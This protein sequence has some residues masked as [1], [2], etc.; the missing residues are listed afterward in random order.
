[1]TDLCYLPGHVLADRIRHGELSAVEV[2]NAQLE[3][4]DKH[5]PEL[6]AVVSLDAGAAWAAAEAAD[7]ALRQGTP[8][9]PLHG[10]PITLKDSID[11]AGLRT[12]I[13]TEMFDRMADRD[14]TVAARLR[15]AGAIV[16]GHSNVP[17][18]LTDYTTANPIFG[19]TGNPW[20]LDH[21]PGGSSGGA[22]AALAAGLTPLEVGSD[23]TGSLRLPAHF[24]GV[25]GLKPTEHR[26]PLTGFFKQPE[27]A[28]RSVR[29]M[30]SL[31]PMA[32]DLGD[33]ALALRLIGGPDE[34][35]TDVPPV[36]WQ[37]PPRRP[38]RALR[39]AMT[40]ALP[41]GPVAAPVRDRVAEVAAAASDAGAGVDECLPELDWDAQRELFVGLLTT[42]LGVFH[43][44]GE[45]D[46]ERR[47]LAAYLRAL[48]GRD[49]LIIAWEEFFSRYDALLL[50]TAMTSAHPEADT[51][52]VDDRPVPALAHGGQLIFA[53]LAGLPSLVVP[54]GLDEEGL[55]IGVQLVGPRWSEPRLL[56]IA[57]QLEQAGILPG[58]A[59]PPGY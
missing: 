27:G 41:G 4:I 3:R 36:P 50:P 5:N 8:L 59:P 48:T 2:L 58:F 7:A 23:L 6:G 42:I 18:F 9:G 16:I 11:V 12:T 56:A 40:P 39:L 51:V 37:E 33:L 49:R 26:V 38:L 13:G 1:M 22:A 10:V 43:P 31:G 28:P 17:P 44:S 15:A 21:T 35:D 30:S 52:P 24:C 57:T 54:A 19:R 47:S 20:R 29:I 34:R 25:Y 46:E 32:R 53:N 14:S 45:L 55:P